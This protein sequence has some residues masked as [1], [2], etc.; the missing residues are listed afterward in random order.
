METRADKR[1]K[2]RGG[3]TWRGWCQKYWLSYESMEKAIKAG[4]STSAIDKKLM[5]K[6]MVIMP[7]IKSSPI[8]ILPLEL[9]LLQTSAVSGQR[10]GGGKKGIKEGSLHFGMTRL[11]S[12]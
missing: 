9:A 7:K 8:A 10:S 5:K 11:R 2:N 3:V 1:N 4:K 6:L 12:G